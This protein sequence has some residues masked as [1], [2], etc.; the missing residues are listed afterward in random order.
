MT[1]NSSSPTNDHVRSLIAASEANIRHITSQIRDLRSKRQKEHNMLATLRMMILP[2]G[3]L[4]TELL[5]EIFKIS[6]EPTVFNLRYP[7]LAIVRVLGHVCSYW[8]QVVNSTP[9]LWVDDVIHVRLGHQKSGLN[10]YLGGLKTVLNRSSPLPISVSLLHK[11]ERDHR[12]LLTDIAPSAPA[13][14]ATVFPTAQR[15]KSLKLDIPSFRCLKT[16]PLT[17]LE[18]LESLDMEYI[19][20]EN[21]HLPT[22]FPSPRLRHLTLLVRGEQKPRSLSMAWSQITELDLNDAPMANSRAILVQCTNLIKATIHVPEWDF[23]DAVDAPVVTLPSLQTLNIRFD[24]GQ[25]EIGQI[26]P[27]FV[28]LALPSLKNMWLDFP[29][30]DPGSQIWPSQEFSSF[31]NR[32]PNIGKLTLT[33]A[34]L[35]GVDLVALLSRTPALTNLDL[36]YSETCVDDDFLSRFQYDA[37]D[38]APLAPKLENITWDGVG[39]LFHA[40]A[41]EAA[42]RSRWWADERLASTSPPR[43]ARLKTVSVSYSG[44]P[45]PLSDELIDRM[46]DI[47]EQ[48]LDLYLF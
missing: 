32:S 23:A 42:I 4:P 20:E 6:L 3:K 31:L 1:G 33:N 8:R 30:E 36:S 48:G 47:A 45:N 24:P 19:E 10:A 2:I 22:F 27:F 35:N 13:I 43:V 26:G 44:F 29:V 7:T 28:P 38:S 17:S 21:N 37:A 15:W 5:V 41:L 9:R 46:Q 34:T 39:T 25:D 14:L 40:D 12:N 16:F 18:A 11:K